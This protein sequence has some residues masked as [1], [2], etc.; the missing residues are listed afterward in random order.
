MEVQS[1]WDPANGMHATPLA[2]NK[3]G[4]AEME[5]PRMQREVGSQV[6]PEILLSDAQADAASKIEAEL[7]Q[8][9]SDAEMKQKMALREA[10]MAVE[11][12]ARIEKD[13][14]EAISRWQ[15]EVETTGAL[16]Q[17]LEARQPDLE[18]VESSR[19]ELFSS[20]QVNT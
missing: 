6:G 13:L 10:K 1:S 5:K 11:A 15:K 17:Q 19:W 7:R 12:Q 4:A 3:H 14:A 8:K 2:A 9:L 18:V 16:R 20:R